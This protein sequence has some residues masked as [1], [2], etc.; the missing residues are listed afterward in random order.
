MMFEGLY[1]KGLE[2]EIRNSYVTLE[3][4]MSFIEPKAY[5][6]KAKTKLIYTVRIKVSS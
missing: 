4:E 3:Q 5:N 6:E 1:A 2:Y